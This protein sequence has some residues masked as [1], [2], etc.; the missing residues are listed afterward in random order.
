M[1]HVSGRLTLMLLIRQ[2]EQLE[3]FVGHMNFI[4]SM[5]EIWRTSAWDVTGNHPTRKSIL[6]NE[7]CSLTRD[8]LLSGLW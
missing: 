3:F 8:K 5:V 6:C 1:G 4:S 2:F 7:S